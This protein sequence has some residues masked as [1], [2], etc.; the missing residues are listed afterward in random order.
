MRVCMFRRKGNKEQSKNDTKHI[1]HRV[2]GHHKTQAQNEHEHGDNLT[3][4]E[5][6][7]QNMGTNLDTDMNTN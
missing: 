4:T 5:T 1:G 3:K 6:W 7:T 2:H